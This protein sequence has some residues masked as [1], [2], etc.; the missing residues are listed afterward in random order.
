MVIFQYNLYIFGI[1]LWTVLYP[2]PCYNESCYKEVVLYDQSI[3]VPFTTKADDNFILFFFFFFFRRKQVLTFHVNRLP[4]RRFTW[5]IKTCFIWKIKNESFRMS[6]ATNFAWRF[7]GKHIICPC[8]IY[9]IWSESFSTPKYWYSFLFLHENICCGYSLEVP[10][11]G[12]SKS[13]HNICF[14]GEIRKMFTWYPLGSRP[15]LVLFDSNYASSVLC[16]ETSNKYLISSPTH[17]LRVF[18]KGL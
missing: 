15:I 3:Q 18:S 5:N 16:R 17:T 12:T 1:H 6:S 8:F 10:W 9:N 13:T 14:C 4:S 11:W 7:K 2:K